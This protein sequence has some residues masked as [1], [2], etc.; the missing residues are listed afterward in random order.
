MAEQTVCFSCL[1][2][3]SHISPSR[4]GKG[5][6]AHLEVPLPY[7]LYRAQ[8]R[9][10][11]DLRGLQDI[12]G[13]LS[14][15]ITDVVPEYITSRV[16][17]IRRLSAQ[18]LGA[19][20]RTN[21]S[22]RMN[23]PLGIRARLNSLGPNSPAP[24]PTKAVSSSV[25]TLKR[26][27]QAPSR[28]SSDESSDSEDIDKS[29]DADRQLEEQQTLDRKLKDL[30]RMMTG[31]RLGLVRN[32]RAKDKNTDRGRT[33]GRSDTQSQY[34]SLDSSI[35]SESVSSAGSP[36]GSI[37][38]IPSPPPEPQTQSPMRKHMGPGKSSSPPALSSRSAL[39]HSH[40]R[41]GGL[42]GMA[43][44]QGS[45][46]ASNHGSSASSFSDLSGT[47]YYLVEYLF[48][49]SHPNRCQPVRFCIRKRAHV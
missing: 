4:L 25:I 19:I 13:T 26:P 11:E 46:S 21:S 40:I 3:F 17:P 35:R 22:M 5:L 20:G 44:G 8:T 32:T 33:G 6:A 7:L 39:S 12:K 49:Y 2:C 41:Y 36:P 30:E 14:P 18:G 29:E 45:D 48:R 1:S 28:S 10:E 24:R 27:L 9:Y 15:I 42:V 31:E 23:T 43:A 16:T 37:P 38:S 47:S 34:R